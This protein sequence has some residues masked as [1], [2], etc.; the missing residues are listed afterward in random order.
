MIKHNKNSVETYPAESILIY[1]AYIFKHFIYIDQ[2]LC[3]LEKNNYFPEIVDYKTIPII[4]RSDMNWISTYDDDN[5]IIVLDVKYVLND[6]KE[7]R[8]LLE[9]HNG[10]DF[11]FEVIELE[12]AN[13]VR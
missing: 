9:K 13:K 2:T 11:Y 1:S 3:V 12:Y 5:R 6:L 7:I 8:D 4:Y 10:L